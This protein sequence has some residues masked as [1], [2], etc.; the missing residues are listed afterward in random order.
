M[1]MQR[2]PAPNLSRCAARPGRRQAAIFTLAASL[3][4]CAIKAVDTLLLWFER[5]RQRRTLGS[6]SDHLLKD[7]GLTRS[8]AGRESAKRFWED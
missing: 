4:I 3:A 8:D 6:L 2:M 1:A 5:G 7:L